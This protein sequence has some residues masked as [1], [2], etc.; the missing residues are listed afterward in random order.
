M[1]EPVKRCSSLTGLRCGLK[2]KEWLAHNYT[3][4]ADEGQNEGHV[5]FCPRQRVVLAERCRRITTAQDRGEEYAL[6]HM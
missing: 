5:C 6:Q 3:G 1:V 4:D 2:T